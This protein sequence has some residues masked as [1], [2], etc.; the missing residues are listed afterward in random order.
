MILPTQQKVLNDLVLPELAYK[1]KDGSKYYGYAAHMCG[2]SILDKLYLKLRQQH[3]EA[4]HIM[5]GYKIATPESPNQCVEGSCHDEESHGDVT[6]A[7]VL[8]EVC[9]NNIAVFVVRYYGGTPLRGL[10]LQLIADCS[11]A[12]LHKL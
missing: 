5:L 7:Q 1:E 12:A 9:M 8:D 4:D 11:K 10:R 2:F 6:L 3:K